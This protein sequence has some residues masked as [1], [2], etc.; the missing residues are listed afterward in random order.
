MLSFVYGNLIYL[1]ASIAGLAI[2]GFMAI[3]FAAAIGM[4]GIGPKLAGTSTGF[5]MT[6]VGI[7][8]LLAPPIGSFFT[9]ITVGT[10]FLFWMGLGILGFIFI[11]QIVDLKP[12]QSV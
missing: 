8:N 7:G 2:N 9:G 11:S 3:V 1:A 6:F 5:I 4:K 10:P 12:E